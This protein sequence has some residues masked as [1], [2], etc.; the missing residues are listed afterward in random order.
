MSAEVSHEKTIEYL[1]QAV[2]AG[3]RAKQLGGQPFGAILV[4][5]DGRVL[6]EQGNVNIVNHAED[7]LCRHA[8]AN[9]PQ[10]TL[11]K[12]TMYASFEPCAMCS[13]AIYWS[14]IGKLVYGI[15]CKGFFEATGFNENN[16]PALKIPCRDVFNA[17]VRK[18]EVVGP[19]PELEKEICKDHLEYW[20]K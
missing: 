19:F 17:G 14:G 10:E 15:D 8:F 13:S 6:A 4:S 11:N 5:E 16:F 7:V 2:E 3:T 1:K 18:V 9:Y 20:K 12:A